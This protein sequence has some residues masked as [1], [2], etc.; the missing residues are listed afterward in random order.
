MS[1]RSPSRF[2]GSLLRGYRWWVAVIVG[3]SGFQYRHWRGRFYPAGLPQD[4]WLEFY[5]AKFRAVELNITFYRL[6]PPAT[7]AEWASRVPDDFVFAV[8][9]S[10]YLTHLRRLLEPEDPVGRLMEGASR[11][12]RKLGPIL[13]QLPPGM[14]AAPDRLERTLAAFPPGVRIALEVRD[15]SWFSDEIRDVLTR[16]GAALCLTDSSYRRSPIW[17]T[18]D[19]TY[20]RFHGGWANPQPCYG[21]AALDWWAR[22]AADGWGP[23][24]DVYAFFNN[25]PAGCALR[26]AALFGRRVGRQGLRST[27][28]PEPASVAV[29]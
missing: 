25:D 29:G 19:W 7:F 10:R 21:R 12:G 27:M 13:I 23:A 4:R 15:R 11:L 22:R 18:A 3:T 26:D 28:T 9:A 8:K 2:G 5:A 16:H 14:R 6:P 24:A 17:R 20:L 1:R